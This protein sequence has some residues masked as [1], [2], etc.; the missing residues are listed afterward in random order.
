[1]ANSVDTDQTPRSA[2]S[3]LCL[4][5]LLRPVSELLDAGQMV[6]EQLHYNLNGPFLLI[7]NSAG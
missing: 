4:H 3:D 5:C 6:A 1:M 2:T 7:L